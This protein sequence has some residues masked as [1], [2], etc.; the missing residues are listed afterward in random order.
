MCGKTLFDAENFELSDSQGFT[1]PEEVVPSVVPLK[2]WL[3]HL[4]KLI[5][6]ICYTSSVDL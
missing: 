4:R 1:S 5:L 6:H 3:L 2:Y